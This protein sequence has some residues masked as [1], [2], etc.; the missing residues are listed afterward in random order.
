[1]SAPYF[2]AMHGELAVVGYEPDG[3]S[4]RFVAQRPSLFSELHRGY[5]IRT[6]SRD[7]SVQ[8]RLEG[9]DAPELH[10]GRAAQP[11][12]DHSRDWLLSQLGF[13][14]VAYQSGVT[15]AVAGG[16]RAASGANRAA[17]ATRPTPGAT[18]SDPGSTKVVHADPETLPAV[19]YTKAS[20]PHGRPIS[21]LQVGT[22]H[23]AKDGA[24]THLTTAVLDRT[25]NAQAL[26]AATAYPTFY[27]STP[28]AHIRHLR[29]QAHAARQDRRGIW[30]D[31]E[32]G[33]FRLT[34]QD[35]IG[36]HGQL[37]LPKLF[38]RAT[39][40]LKDRDAGFRGNLTDW[41]QAN[42]TGSRHENDLVVL[43]GGVEAPLS[44]L[45]YQRNSAIAFGPDLLDVVFVEK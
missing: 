32:T 12:G 22:D 18:R 11:N 43:R 4:I 20:D 23:A 39:D 15:K 21:Y 36:P 17:P 40:Y 30:A 19:I 16:S 5:K 2:L 34:D 44:T 29:G 14:Q 8:L 28:A 37:I 25:V 3:D 38:R 41:L 9:I 31:D 7:A 42:D 33:L 24:W 10:Y 45:L 6:S 27:T 35:S 26:T 13:R 1:M